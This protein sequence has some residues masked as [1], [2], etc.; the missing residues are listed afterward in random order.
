MVS[1]RVTHASSGC[2]IVICLYNHGLSI[3]PTG[4]LD[5]GVRGL[6]KDA[7]LHLVL[8]IYF[9][10]VGT[11]PVNARPNEQRRSKRRKKSVSK[12]DG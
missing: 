8:H 6:I 9:F 7:P 11:D 10:P 1:S 3:F 5:E 4:F 2:V 12:R